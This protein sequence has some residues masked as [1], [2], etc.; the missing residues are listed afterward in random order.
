MKAV[1]YYKFGTPEVLNI[2][3]VETPVPKDDEVLVKIYAFAV[4][5]EDPGT[6]AAPGFNGIFKPRNPILG[7]YLSG[8]VVGAGKDVSKFKNGDKVY[9]DVGSKY[10]SYAQFIC[11]SE[12]GGI[13]TMPDNMTFEEAAAIP[14]GY[15]TALPFLK[16]RANV[17]KGDSVLIN[18]ASGAVGSAAVRLAKHFG[19]EVTGVC[20]KENIEMVKSLGA[21]M[22]IDYREKDFT[23]DSIKYDIIFDT[24]GKVGFSKCKSVLKDNGI[25]ITTIPNLSIMIRKL[26]NKKKD[27][28]TG[29][30]AMGLRKPPVKARDLRYLTT[31]A[32]EGNIKAVI[33][34]VYSMEE[35]REA[36]IYVKQGHKKGNVIVKVMHEDD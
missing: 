22:T 1:V 28:R 4:A 2:G 24:V 20:S 30:G 8:V 7:E 10:G 26:I 15:L 35:I 31:L 18:G 12:N 25:F 13:A 29:F 21:D 17:K 23:Q 3:E 5:K 14:N 36:H 16:E 19:A 34:R 9:A 6:R 11:I 27:K 33:D 32:N